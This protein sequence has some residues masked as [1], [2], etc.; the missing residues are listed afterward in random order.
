MPSERLSDQSFEPV[1]TIGKPNVLF[2][3]NHTQSWSLIT[4][5][6][7]KN[8]QLGTGDFVIGLTENCLEV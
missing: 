2:G 3:N 7:G 5:I 4:V 8:Q 1:S 6:N